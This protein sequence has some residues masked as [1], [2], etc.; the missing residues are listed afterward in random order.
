M[1]IKYFHITICNTVLSSKL[2]LLPS[3]YL[4]VNI[5]QKYHSENKSLLRFFKYSLELANTKKIIYSHVTKV[6]KTNYED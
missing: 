3:T 6:K 5:I 2:K 4:N 1:C